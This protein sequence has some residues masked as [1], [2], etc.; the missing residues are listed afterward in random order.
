MPARALSQ[1]SIGYCEAIGCAELV[2]AGT[3]FCD[4]HD[5]MLQSDIQTILGKQYRPGKKQTKVFHITLERAKAEI[6][7]CQTGGYRSPRPVEF[8]W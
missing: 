8:E 2:P 6:L 1:Q 4:R 3:L 5:A 7:F